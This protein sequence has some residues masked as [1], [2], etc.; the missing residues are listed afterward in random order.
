M[1]AGKIMW[2]LYEHPEISFEEMSM[3]FMDIRKRVYKFPKMGQKAYFIA[4]PTSSGTGSEVTPFA[5]ITDKKIKYPLTDYE[6]LPN[7]SI[8]DVNMMMNAPKGLTSFSGIDAVTHALEAYASMMA[9]DYTDAL[10]IGALKS[11]FKYLPRA[12]ENGANDV[13]ARE[14]MANAA[15]MAGMAFANAFLG[16]CHSMAHKLGAFHNLPHGLANALLITHIMRFNASSVPEKMG[17]FPKYSYPHTLSRYVEIADALN[18]S[19]DNDQDKLDNLIKAIDDLKESIGIKFSIKDYGIT[20][21]DFLNTL[22]EMTKQAFDDQCTGSN[23]RYPLMS[24][25]K[26]I[27]LRAF[28]GKVS[29]D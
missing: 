25:I 10:A 27:Y 6:L 12:Y 28:Y 29:N 3:R 24:E 23:P 2:V 14:K 18:I 9:S 21:E 16:V 26:N 20:E 8:I 4:I 13:E 19:G 15:T 5:V 1:D 22:D 11:I 7:M 17:T